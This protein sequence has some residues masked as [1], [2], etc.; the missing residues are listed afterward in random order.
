MLWRAV[1]HLKSADIQWLDLGGVNAEAPG[2]AS[3]KAGMGGAPVTLVG[4]YV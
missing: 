4:G 2:V 1:E 3:F